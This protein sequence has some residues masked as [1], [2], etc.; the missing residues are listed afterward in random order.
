MS[1][2]KIYDLP[3]QNELTSEETRGIFGRGRYIR[4]AS[5]PSGIPAVVPGYPGLTI[6]MTSA[7][8][9]FGF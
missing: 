7:L 9:T 8:R 5:S 6:S 3:A 1:R 2:I 4:V